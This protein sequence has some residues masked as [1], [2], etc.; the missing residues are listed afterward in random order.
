MTKSNVPRC[1]IRSRFR[2]RAW[3]KSNSSNDLAA[4]E[5]GG[6]D[7]SFAAVRVSGSDLTL[8]AGDQE[9]LMRPRLGPGP[10]GEP[11]PTLSRNVG[12]FNARVKN[13]NSQQCLWPGR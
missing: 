12:A 8:Q 9:L 5:P 3:S 6:P 7:P 13:A 1:K 11:V 2:P 4:G 10:L